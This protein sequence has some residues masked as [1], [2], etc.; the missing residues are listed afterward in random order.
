MKSSLFH[1]Q[2]EESGRTATTSS[3][4]SFTSVLSRMVSKYS[5]AKL[6]EGIR[7]VHPELQGDVPDS[8]TSMA[9]TFA[10]NLSSVSINKLQ[11]RCHQ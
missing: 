2:L 1:Q 6:A 5:A 11:A 8:V 9:N 10:I 7:H 3:E 4:K